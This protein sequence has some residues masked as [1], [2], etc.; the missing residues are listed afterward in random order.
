[1][2]LFPSGQARRRIT[3]TG[4]KG[5]GYRRIQQPQRVES[6][7]EFGGFVSTV[8]AV[9]VERGRHGGGTSVG[10]VGQSSSMA[11]PEILAAAFQASPSA[12]MY[13]RFA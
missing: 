4:P 7:A 9:N 10:A 8:E 6:L 12:R 3:L 1:M 13:S 2:A 11:R 5:L